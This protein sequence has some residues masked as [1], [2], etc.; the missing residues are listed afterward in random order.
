MELTF[1]I[2]WVNFAGLN[3]FS[4]LFMQILKKHFR[5]LP[6]IFLLIAGGVLILFPLSIRGQQVQPQKTVLLNGQTGFKITRNGSTG[7][8]F[9]NRLAS[10]DVHEEGTTKGIFSVIGAEGYASIH[11]AGDPSL[12][13]LNKLIEVPENALVKVTITRAVYKEYD[14]SDLGIRYRLIPAQLPVLKTDIDPRTIP[15]VM[16]VVTYNSNSYGDTMTVRTQDAGLLRGVRLMRIEVVPVN[17]NPVT[18]KLRICT[19][20]EAEVSFSISKSAIASNLSSPYFENIFS[21]T[22]NHSKPTLKALIVAQPVTY[23]VLA[24]PMFKT[25]LKPFI[26]WKIKK[27]FNVIEVYTDNPAVGTTPVAIKQYLQNIYR[28]PPQGMS[29]PSFLL[30]VGDV[31]LLPPFHSESGQHVTDLYYAEYSGD[32]LPELFYGRFPASTVAELQVMIDK[33]LEYEKYVMHDPSYLGKAALISGADASHQLNWSNGQIRYASENYFNAAQNI[34]ASVVLQPSTI[35]DVDKTMQSIASGVGFANYTAH[36]NAAGWSNPKLTTAELTNLQNDHKYTLMVGNCCQSAR[37]DQDCLA[38]AVLKLPG[39]GAIGYIGGSNDTYWDE[40]YWWSNGFKAITGN[41]SYDA[42]HPGALDGTFHTHNEGTDKWFITQGQLLVAGNLAVEQSNSTLK[43]YYWEIYC[44]MGDPSLSMYYGIPK[45]LSHSY[46]QLLPIGATSFIIHTDP[47]AYAAISMNG[48][49][50]GATMAGTDGVAVV[51]MS[52]ITVAGDADIVITMQNRQPYQGTV[53]VDSP[54]GAYML[55]DTY[56]LHDALG[57]NDGFADYGEQPSLNISI[58]NF[59]QLASGNLSLKLTSQ[60]KFVTVKQ[61]VASWGSVTPTGSATVNDAFA[62]AIDSLTPDREIANLSLEV[63]DGTNSWTSKFTLPIRS[64]RLEVGTEVIDDAATGNGNGLADPGESFTLKIPITN[65]GQSMATG[66]EVSISTDNQY[67]TLNNSSVIIGDMLPGTQKQAVFSISAASNAP[68]G[69]MPKVTLQAKASG[70]YTISKD[71]LLTIGII[72]EDFE[73]NNFDHL[74]WEQSGS[75]SWTISNINPQ[76][77][78]FSARSGGITHAQSST[79]SVTF[80]ILH[81]GKISFFKKVSSE[82]GYDRLLFYIDNL[83]VGEWSGQQDWEKASFDVTAGTHTFRWTY[84]K[85]GATSVG[86]DCAWIDNIIFPQVNTS[87][88]IRL[89]AMVINDFTGNKNGQLDPGESVNITLPVENNGLNPAVDAVAKLTCNSPYIT[90]NQTEVNL[91]T[92]V[93]GSH[94][95]PS[96]AASVSKTAPIGIAVDLVFRLDALTTTAQKSFIRVIGNTPLVEDFERGTFTSLNWL[97]GGNNPWSIENTS[98]SLTGKFSARSGMI[99]DMQSSDLLISLEV[100]ADD[101][102]RFWL[103]TST[104]KQADYLKF[105]IDGQVKGSWSGETPWKRVAF[106]VPPGIHTF[107]WSY[108]KDYITLA[109]SDAVWIDNIQFP[110]VSPSLPL[111]MLTSVNPVRICQGESAVLS[112][113]A[114]GGTGVYS[115]SWKPASG[116]SNPVSATTVA[117]PDV[118]T[119]YVVEVNDGNVTSSTTVHLNVLKL[120]EKPVITVSPDSRTLYSSV[121]NGYQWFKDTILI[122]GATTSS[123]VPTENGMYAVKVFNYNCWSE[124]STLYQF[125]STGL[126]SSEVSSM[127]DFSP[128]PFTSVLN[129]HFTLTESSPLSLTLCDLTGRTINR[130]V[131]MAIQSP[132]DYRKTIILQSLQKGVYLIVMKTKGNTII[133]KVV[134]N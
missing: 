21:L 65:A 14:A 26:D 121:L 61:S 130:V 108:Q 16:N 53:K 24:N 51:N 15:F 132:G 70:N 33:T 10:I 96:F 43:S 11:V 82:A 23:I 105:F 30:I 101:S 127:L 89:G 133:R 37:F 107:E 54:S 114:S 103:K 63:M 117:M 8:H 27:G 83:L 57:N 119:D 3:F 110:P 68:L 109:G 91:G 87:P 67:L 88:L 129:L 75:P 58:K 29:A 115:Y 7:F 113:K 64:R 79:L 122:S 32:K 76:Q 93:R 49:L 84:L 39:K 48:K 40:D 86:S 71:Y 69:T 62:I 35:A 81:D 18:Q 19:E 134:K 4:N 95:Q 45:P 52:P 2:I 9:I 42:Q 12:P 85:D 77:G 46:L 128:N 131:E 80:N 6:L 124:H 59:G 41:P 104:E 50:Y 125:I 100:V 28:N 1:L 34:D 126:P 25:A 5:L 44:L 38:T 66:T 78:T 56:T 123:Y 97:S 120:P 118:T 106:T 60:D 112:V 99:K 17:Y 72:S 31:N 13:V 55:L 73:A 92:L 20:L 98:T 111:A 102:I 36:C 74:P 22:A 116:L 94:Y 90:I 47:Y